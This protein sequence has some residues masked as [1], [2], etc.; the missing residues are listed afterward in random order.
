[1]AAI[2]IYGISLN[3]NYGNGAVITTNPDPPTDLTEDYTQRS[4]SSLGLTWTQA[5][6]NGGAIIIDYQI[7]IAQQGESFIILASGVTT[8]SFSAIGL[9]AGVAY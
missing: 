2:N 1:V 4:K 6:F 3:S 5:P 7:S 8:T 9:I